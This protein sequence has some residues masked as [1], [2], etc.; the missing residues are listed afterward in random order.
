M[1]W[2]KTIRFYRWV[3][4]NHPDKWPKKIPFAICEIKEK[5]V[6]VQVG[7]YGFDKKFAHEFF[8]IPLLWLNNPKL[9][10]EWI[11]KRQY[12]YALQYIDNILPCKDLRL[13][14]DV[15][16]L[17]NNVLYP[18]LNHCKLIREY[19]LFKEYPQHGNSFAELK[20]KY[21]KEICSIRKELKINGF[22]II[23][24]KNNQFRMFTLDLYNFSRLERSLFNLY[25]WEECIIFAKLRFLR[26]K[27]QSFIKTKSHKEKM[28]KKLS[29]K[30]KKSEMFFAGLQLM[31]ARVTINQQEV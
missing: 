6:Q 14:H 19:N 27:K 12:E 30:N 21:Q 11:D 13:E 17:Q 5:I 28:E 23:N 9:Y 8:D 2:M 3:I 7:G 22:K 16:I 31:S 25:G 10:P 4:K 18:H 24:F 1:S 20:K 26:Y 29:R 15:K